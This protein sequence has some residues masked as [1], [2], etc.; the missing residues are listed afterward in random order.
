MNVETRM[1]IRTAIWTTLA[2]VAALPV[3]VASAGLDTD[4]WPWLATIVAAATA[5]TRIVNTPAVE[6]LL[7]RVGLGRDGAHEAAPDDAAQLDGAGD[8]LP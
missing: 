7:A 5:I 2:L 1:S 4:R 3:L 8:T 6:E